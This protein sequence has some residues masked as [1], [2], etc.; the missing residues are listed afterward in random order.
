MTG[1]AKLR[2]PAWSIRYEIRLSYTALGQPQSV[3]LVSADGRSD[4]LDHRIDYASNEHNQLAGVKSLA[5]DFAYGYEAK[6]PPR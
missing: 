4:A 2:F 5:G 1:D 3:Y 6:I